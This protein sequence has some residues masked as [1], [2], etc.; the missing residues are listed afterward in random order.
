MIRIATRRSPLA[1]AQSTMVARRISELSGLETTLVEVVSQ[2]DTDSRP[3]TEFG[4]VG[5]FVSAV[6]EAVLK[7]DADVAVHSLK[8]A[9]TAPGPLEL[10]AIPVRED[11][12]DALCTDGRRLADLPAGATVGTGSPRR[13]AQLKSLRPDLDIVPIRGNVGTRLAHVADGRLDAVVLAMAGLT[14]LGLQSAA[15]ELFSTTDMAPAPGQG[16]L[17]IEARTSDLDPSAAEALTQ[18]LRTLDDPATRAATTAER[19]FLATLEAGCSAPLGAFGLIREDGFWEPEVHLTAAL[20]HPDG[21][22]LRLSTTGSA[23][24]AEALG[25]NLATDALGRYGYLGGLT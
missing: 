18:T 9:P 10:T 21:S 16:A 24:D 8:D 25:R 15:T 14:R 7:G 12:R 22:V 13:T 19:S 1:L 4:G 3:L 11:P 23:G 5:V 2:G 6:R 17:L 20:A